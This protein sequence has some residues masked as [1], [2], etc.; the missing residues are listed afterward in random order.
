MHFQGCGRGNEGTDNNE[1]QIAAVLYLMHIEDGGDSF[2]R[3]VLAL[4]TGQEVNSNRQ[5]SISVNALML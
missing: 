5:L 1:G 3:N 2:H 4:L